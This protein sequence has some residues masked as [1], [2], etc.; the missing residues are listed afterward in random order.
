MKIAYVYDAVCGALPHHGLRPCPCK[1]RRGLP[2]SPVRAYPWIKG[3]AEKRI[4]E[5]SKRLVERGHEVHPLEAFLI[6][7]FLKV[8]GMKWWDGVRDIAVDGVYLH[9]KGL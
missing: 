7:L 6:K 8:C 9:G 4:Y 2:A 5:I 1:P 3:G